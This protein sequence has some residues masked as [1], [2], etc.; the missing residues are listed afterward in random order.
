MS[1]W[2]AERLR[3]VWSSLAAMALLGSLLVLATP[4]VA[5]AAGEGSITGVVQDELGQPVYD[6]QVQVYSD[7]EEYYDSEW[8][9][10]DGTFA[11]D[12]LP[13]GNYLL[14]V[15]PPGGSNLLTEWWENAANRDGAT[16]VLVAANAATP[17]TVTLEAGDSI[18]GVVKNPA[19][20]PLG[21]VWVEAFDSSGE[22]V[23][24]AAT[25]A[26]GVFTVSG[27]RSG[28]H[29]LCFYP[30]WESDLVSLCGDDAI[31]AMVV[32]GQTTTLGDVVLPQ[33]GSIAGVVKDPVGQPVYDVQIEAVD[34]AGNFVGATYSYSDGTFTLRGLLPGQHT[35]CFFAP[36]DTDLLDRCGVAATVSAGQTADLGVVTLDSST[37]VGSVPVISGVAG[38]G[39]TLSVVPGAWHP[40][41]LSFSYLWFRDD[42]PTGGATT[43]TY[44]VPTADVGKRISVQLIASKAGYQTVVS[45]VSEKTPA[46]PVPPAPPVPVPPVPPVVEP[47]VPVQGAVSV[48]V[49]STSRSAGDKVTVSGKAPVKGK[50][51]V[52]VQ[53]RL[54]GSS[55]WKTIA[56]AKTTKKGAFKVSV[57]LTGVG[58]RQL[59]V[60]VAGVAGPVTETPV[61]AVKPRV[62]KVS[63]KVGA[64]KVVSGK[65]VTVSGKTSPRASKQPVLVQQQVAG[66][67]EWTT[68]KSVKTSKKGTFKVKV[69]VSGSQAL[70]FRV[71][72]PARGDFAEGSSA[73]SGLVMVT[74]K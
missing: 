31:A 13:P 4:V 58:D 8:T 15:R 20:Q 61:V 34:S 21:D 47:V 11:I 41:G 71:L 37:I 73:A 49:G 16:P 40:A 57:K 69:P 64:K 36:W 29:T 38:V 22:Y 7:N 14:R 46:V 12:Y 66:S 24:E 39:Q 63:V 72:V 56:K 23:M 27:L 62:L 19:G 28:A 74:P 42:D 45:P 9:S 25:G 26:D 6:A 32:E 3:K 35:L 43:A 51:K 59:R 2:V 17:L 50:K 44:T 10:E 5:Q 33:G 30:P 52:Q 65:S 68:V 54:V 53:Q 60:V 70:R 1:K 48:K 55:V 67:P 18:T